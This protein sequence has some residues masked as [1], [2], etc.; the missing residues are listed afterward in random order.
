MLNYK[1]KV[2]KKSQRIHAT[3]KKK[4]HDQ[5]IKCKTSAEVLKI[6][7]KCSRLYLNKVASQRPSRSG[8]K[9]ERNFTFMVNYTALMSTKK[10]VF[11]LILHHCIFV[12]YFFFAD[13]NLPVFSVWIIFFFRIQCE[14]FIFRQNFICKNQMQKFS[15]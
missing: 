13:G 1:R 12:Y 7:K 11:F 5:K 4:L 3:A 14:F 15:K 9:V 2:K 10:S 6:V 8:K